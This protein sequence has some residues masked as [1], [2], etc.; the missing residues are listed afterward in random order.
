MCLMFQLG[1]LALLCNAKKE[2]YLHEIYVCFH[3]FFFPSIPYLG[4]QIRCAQN[5]YIVVQMDLKYPLA[6]K[7]HMLMCDQLVSLDSFKVH[8]SSSS[9]FIQKSSKVFQHCMTDPFWMK[10]KH[11]HHYICLISHII[12]SSIIWLFSVC[13]VKFIHQWALK[14]Y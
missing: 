9:E 3:K 4:V 13:N 11:L 8:A 10:M 14:L 7:D 5:W 12:I 2:K 1:V 6:V